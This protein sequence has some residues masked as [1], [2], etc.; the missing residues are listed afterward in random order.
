MK[1]PYNV[2]KW[3]VEKLGGTMMG[4]LKENTFP[5]H[6]YPCNIEE[7][8]GFMTVDPR[9][10]NL[11]DY[12]IARVGIIRKLANTIAEEHLYATWIEKIDPRCEKVWVKL[13]VAKPEGKDDGRKRLV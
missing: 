9:F 6:T 1:I 7:L 3:A 11:S 2:R 5:F 4:P 13:M 10:S 12:D 8:V